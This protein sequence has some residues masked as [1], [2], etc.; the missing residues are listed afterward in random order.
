MPT[1]AHAVGQ[2]TKHAA[3]RRATIVPP[4]AGRGFIHAPPPPRSAPPWHRNT[5]TCLTHAQ[6]AAYLC[7]LGARDLLKLEEDFADA[8]HI[9]AH[10]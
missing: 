2:R 5:P 10:A 7:C 9:V 1:R 6:E 4:V 3:S 8:G